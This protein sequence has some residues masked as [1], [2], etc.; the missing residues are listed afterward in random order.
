MET[1]PDDIK[2]LIREYS[3]DRVGVHP[4]AR[5][6]KNLTFRH[7]LPHE[8]HNDGYES[9]VV[10]THD[11]FIK[12]PGISETLDWSD[13]LLSLKKKELD[14]KIVMETLGCIIKSPDDINKIDDS[15]VNDI[16]KS[17]IS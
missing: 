15:R 10:E 14:N 9:T 3:S 2:M 6:I 16:L 1:L 17:I 11:Y 12:K 7:S 4:T 8:F 5:L 13:A